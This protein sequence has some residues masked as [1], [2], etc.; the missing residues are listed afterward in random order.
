[1]TDRDPSEVQEVQAW[2]VLI[3]GP[4]QSLGWMS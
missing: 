3:P 4:R 1:M 2:K